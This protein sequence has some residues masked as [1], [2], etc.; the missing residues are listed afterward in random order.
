MVYIWNDDNDYNFFT[1]FNVSHN[2]I[3]VCK[4]KKMGVK[5]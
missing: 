2:S 5:K 1:P 3:T 4:L